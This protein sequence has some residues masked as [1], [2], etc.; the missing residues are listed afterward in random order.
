VPKTS[1]WSNLR[2][3][4]VSSLQEIV[5]VSDHES[6]EFDLCPD[7]DIIIEDEEESLPGP[8]G[9]NNKSLSNNIKPL[10][11]KNQVGSKY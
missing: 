6:P 4:K 1:K 11:N 5:T 7:D 10:F 2:E 9:F 3:D 8:V